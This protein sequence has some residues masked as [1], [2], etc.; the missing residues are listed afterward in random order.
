MI[1]PIAAM[2]AALGEMQALAGAATAPAS[3]QLVPSIGVDG[4]SAAAPS[5]SQALHSAL[6]RVDDAI[7]HA[8]GQSQ[9]FAAGDQSIPLSDVMVSLEQ[10]NLSL[11]MAAGVRDKVVAAYTN[12]MNMQV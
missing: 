6:G 7:A 8:S 12:I 3:S 4:A 10:A 2:N 9:A 1:D 5:F 11:Q